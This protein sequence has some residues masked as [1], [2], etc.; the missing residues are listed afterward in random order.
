[1]R[2]EGFEIRRMLF[3]SEY[4]LAVYEGK[5]SGNGQICLI[6][7]AD[8]S[9]NDN[10]SQDGWYEVYEH[11]QLTV[12]N[13]KHLPR[14]SSIELLDG[15]RVYAILEAQEGFMLQEV[16]NFG[17]AEVQQ[18][19]EAVHHLHNK[20][21]VHGAIVPENVWITKE[22]KVQ[23]YGAGEMK[24]LGRG[25]EERASAD[26]RQ[27]VE[28]IQNYSTLD[29][30]MVEQLTLDNPTSI[31]ELE[32]ILAAVPMEQQIPKKK[33]GSLVEKEQPA[34]KRKV[35]TLSPV[36]KQK[37]TKPQPV[38]TKEKAEL[39]EEFVRP[40]VEKKPERQRTN[41]KPERQRTEQKQQER[42]SRKKWWGIGA[43]ALVAAII[44]GNVVANSGENNSSKNGNEMPQV[45]SQLNDMTK[46]NGSK[47]NQ[48]T[49]VVSNQITDGVLPESNVRRVT[50]K[51]VDALSRS[52]LRLA[53]NEIFARHG[54]VFKSEDL[55]D[56]FAKQS[57][58]K[59]DTSYTGSID[60]L[61]DIEKYNVT[62]IRSHEAQATGVI[63]PDS[64]DRKLTNAEVEALTKAQLRLARNEIF[65]RYGYVFQSEDLR[66]HFA[67]LS[68]YKPDPS[69]TGSIDI[70]NEV[71]K[72]NVKLLQE[73]EAQK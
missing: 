9:G 39:E 47:T 37:R 43:A 38:W 15:A 64:S 3:S 13:Y 32:T 53:R 73:K 42:S 23:L 4:G 10:S 36:P 66:Q 34:P 58:Y 61:N 27:L 67:K 6:R 18:L 30:A 1:M 44:I 26:V 70:M 14:V 57:W 5:K 49:A 40:R 41:Q 72:Y 48:S 35:P 56:Y 29:E 54:Y 51:E 21:L 16:S 63:F 28:T 68:W 20:K 52:E 25:Q 46:T 59:P 50:A 8:Y 31:Q 17:L 7:V 12:T 69:Y 22:G 24:A 45:A 71:E 33:K 62:L 65:A 2:I 60:S 19:V 11:Y 55:R